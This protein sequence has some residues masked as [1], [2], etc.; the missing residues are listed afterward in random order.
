MPPDVQ[1]VADL[2]RL[3][4]RSPDSHKGTFGR[5]VLVAGSRGMSGAAVLCGSAALR[6]GAGLVT[7]ACPRDIQGWVAVGNPC[8]TTISLSQREDGAFAVSAPDELYTTAA[9]ADAVGI[10][11]GLGSH[12][13]TRDLIRQF[14]LATPS[15][16]TVLDA[17]GLNA[18][19]PVP[20]PLAERTAPLV[21][22]PHP[23]EFA[24]LLG[25]PTEQV[26]ANRQ[27]LAVGFAMKWSAV[28]VLKGH[29]TIVTDGNRVFVNGT[30]NPGLATGGTGDVLTG[31]ITALVAQKVPAFD[32]AVLGTWVHGRAADHAAA[33]LGQLA[34]TAGDLLTYLP[35]AL[36]EV[37]G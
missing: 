15:T 32:A 25:I 5:A 33:D 10:G 6:G 13:S 2:P 19:V 9:G 23:G 29:Q 24:R 7:V 26:Q 17:D 12:P 30:G 18:L 27:E 14:L 28:I 36:R 8:Y 16:P 31:L 34:L 4:P 11:P 37:G 21:M 1:T 22:T 35:R 20:T 3:L